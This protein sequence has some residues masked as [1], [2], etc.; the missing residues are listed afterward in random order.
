MWVGHEAAFVEYIQVIAESF[1]A[2]AK[3]V[4]DL[5]RDKTAH[6]F[7]IALEILKEE[8]WGE[9]HDPDKPRIPFEITNPFAKASDEMIRSH[10][11]ELIRQHPR[12]WI[13][14]PDVETLDADPFMF[15]WK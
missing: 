5:E 4:S 3:S 15:D 1:H 13:D 7:L 2:H 14:A 6:A 11:A 9:N 10:W 8:L 12:Y